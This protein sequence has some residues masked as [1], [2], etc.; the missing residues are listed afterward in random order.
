[1]HAK[2]H[3]MIRSR[4]HGSMETQQNLPFLMLLA[5]YVVVNNT[6]LFSVVVGKWVPFT[7]FSSYKIF[8]IVINNNKY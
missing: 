3:N 2:Q 6:K 8:H 1:M 5:L 7:L 4:N